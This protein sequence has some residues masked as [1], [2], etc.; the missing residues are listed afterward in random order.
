MQEMIRNNPNVTPQM[1]SQF[2]A[3]A[4]N[5]AMIEQVA[6]Q[7]QNPQAMAQMQAMMNARGAGM[8]GAMPNT[9]AFGGTSTA[10]AAG[11]GASQ[12]SNNNAATGQGQGNDQNQTEDEVSA[13]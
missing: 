13:T 6:R 1:R 8:P 11:G 4:S 3:I 9:G 12:S 5:P 2:E 10:P 7:M